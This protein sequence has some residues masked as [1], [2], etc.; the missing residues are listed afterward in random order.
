MSGMA[1]AA[2]EGTTAIGLV[3]DLITSECGVLFDRYV[4][5][6][7]NESSC[8]STVGPTEK[9]WPN[10]WPGRKLRIMLVDKRTNPEVRWAPAVVQGWRQINAGPMS[11]S[12]K[13]FLTVNLT[14]QETLAVGDPDDSFRSGML[15]E[16][17]G[18]KS[19]KTLNGK[20]G[21][22]LTD[23]KNEEGRYP[24]H[25]HKQN[26]SVMV[27]PIN[28]QPVRKIEFRLE[29][30]NINGGGILNGWKFTSDFHDKKSLGLPKKISFEW[31]EPADPPAVALEPVSID[32][33]EH[34]LSYDDTTAECGTR[35]R[36]L[37]QEVLERLDN[38]STEA[39]ERYFETEFA[40][41]V[42]RLADPEDGNYLPFERLLMEHPISVWTSAHCDVV[43]QV[44]EHGEMA[45]RVVLAVCKR[46]FETGCLKK[47]G[48]L[49]RYMLEFQPD[50]SNVQQASGD[51]VG[52][53]PDDLVNGYI[54]T[55]SN[56][57]GQFCEARTRDCSEALPWS[58]QAVEHARGLEGCSP[59]R[60]LA[61]TYE[62]C[63][64]LADACEI[65]QEA[66][67]RIADEYDLEEVQELQKARTEFLKEYKRWMGTAG[68]IISEDGTKHIVPG[69]RSLLVTNAVN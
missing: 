24:I 48:F 51:I 21:V 23:S 37:E 31:L 6:V 17:V 12:T 15:V 19:A 8:Y 14:Q 66:Y 29:R 2:K 54:V 3:R 33:A 22:V 36:Q 65:F 32:E 61:E 34:K 49:K 68:Y 50:P 40:P 57:I 58:K 16:L 38:G 41:E 26:K 7:L 5:E 59:F 47:D 52:S 1:D 28:L 9:Q 25:I 43:K 10:L 55:L 67:E 39:F 63:G 44:I 11:P 56:L 53:L 35:R 13:W 45:A 69:M 64:Y 18:L 27:K 60:Y 46:R 30:C 4:H 62:R 20:M 42:W